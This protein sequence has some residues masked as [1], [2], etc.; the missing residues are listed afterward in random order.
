L[1]LGDIEGALSATEKFPKIPRV[2]LCTPGNFGKVFSPGRGIL[3]KP[4]QTG[5]TIFNVP[6]SSITSI[7]EIIM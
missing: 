4:S 7:S 2:K 6:F 5:Q 3:K 1:R